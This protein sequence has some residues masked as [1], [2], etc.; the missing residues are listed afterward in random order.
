MK[1]KFKRKWKIERGRERKRII[2]RK[3]KGRI[4]KLRTKQRRERRERREELVGRT[5][6]KEGRTTRRRG[7]K[8]KKK[9]NPEGGRGTT[10]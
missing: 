9:G 6:L 5:K 1:E 7:K 2:D 4:T 3:E 8:K 10:W